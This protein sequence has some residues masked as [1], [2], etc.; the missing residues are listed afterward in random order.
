LQ[1]PFAGLCSTNT[2]AAVAELVEEKTSAGQAAAGMVGPPIGGMPG[3]D[4]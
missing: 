4:M 3:M 2:D 1:L